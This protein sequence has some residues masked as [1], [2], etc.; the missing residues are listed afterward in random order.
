MKEVFNF[1][2][3]ITHA[4]IFLY[5]AFTVAQMDVDSQKRYQQ[6]KSLALALLELR[7]TPLQTMNFKAKVSVTHVGDFP[8]NASPVNLDY[9]EK[10]A[11]VI[12]LGE[13]LGYNSPMAKILDPQAYA[14]LR[15]GNIEGVDSPIFWTNEIC[16]NF[17]CELYC[18]NQKLSDSYK[19]LKPISKNESFKQFAGGILGEMKL[20]AILSEIAKESPDYRFTKHPRPPAFI[21][22]RSPYARSI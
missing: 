2:G 19:R 20:D 1:Q 21:S 18:D 9:F 17:S 6:Q 10:A 16:K 4:R 14:R 15:I 7:A 13:E 8:I 5:E 11:R 22:P 3:V 12:Q